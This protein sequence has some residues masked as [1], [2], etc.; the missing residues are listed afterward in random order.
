MV[1]TRLWAECQV[2][3]PPA[4]VGSLNK[5]SMPGA[6]NGAVLGVFVNVCQNR[7]GGGAFV[8]AVYRAAAGNRHLMSIFRTAFRN[9]QIVPAVFLIDMRTLRTASSRTVPDVLGFTE[10]F[11]GH[12]VD[13]A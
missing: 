6:L 5:V 13:F 7:V 8:W 2:D 12:R 10:L 11:A 9:Q 1:G 4:S 3:H